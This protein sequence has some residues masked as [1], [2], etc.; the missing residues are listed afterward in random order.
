MT[1]QRFA[2]ITASGM[3]LF[4]A[5]ACHARLPIDDPFCNAL[6][7]LIRA[8][9]EPDPFS[10]IR[11]A[12]VTVPGIADPCDY[13]VAHGPRVMC[14]I[15]DSRPANFDSLVTQTTRCLGRP[16]STSGQAGHRRAFFRQDG[17][18]VGMHED[19]AGYPKVLLVHTLWVNLQQV[20]PHS[21]GNE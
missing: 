3:F 8:A 11:S 2:W 21:G 7:R 20:H 16:F 9:H 10:S 1:A 5:Q 15:E 6:D 19:Q 13:V 14:R 18:Y 17:V 4:T 12:S